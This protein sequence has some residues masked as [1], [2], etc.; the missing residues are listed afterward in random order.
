MAH[1]RVTAN[2]GNGL[3]PDHVRDMLPWYV[4][5]TLSPVERE[6]VDVWLGRHPEGRA[7][8]EAL[9]RLRDAVAA[10][11]PAAPP[12][13][14]WAHLRARVRRRRAH[15]LDWLAWAW[16]SLLAAI[17][18]LLLWATVRPG[19]VLRWEVNG[20]TPA[21]VRVWRVTNGTQL[22]PLALIPL[23]PDQHVGT[24]VDPLVRPWE[25]YTYRVEMLDEQGRLTWHRTVVTPANGVW[26]YLAGI[27]VVSLI[28]GWGTA[29]GIFRF[30]RRSVRLFAHRAC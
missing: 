13:Q 10:Q 5:G 19:I 25:T 12:E 29:W 11:P 15:Q 16:G 22:I 17:L 30:R 3:M 2:G 4:N 26:G 24:F 18:F 23:T 8:V 7:E 28:G 21:I 20:A 6:A 9:R 14:V 27:G 1:E